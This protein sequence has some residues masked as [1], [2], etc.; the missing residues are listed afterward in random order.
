MY[1]R[2]DTGFVAGAAEVICVA[3]ILGYQ[4]LWVQTAHVRYE[5]IVTPKGRKITVKGPYP[6][7]TR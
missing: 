2:T 1:R 6:P 5:L 7:V 3:E 4:V